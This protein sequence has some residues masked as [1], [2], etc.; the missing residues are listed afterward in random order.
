PDICIIGAGAAGL[1]A[2]EA[3][4]GHGASVV[5]VE[6]DRM[7]GGRLH[8][9]SVPARALSAAA[10]RAHALRT[11]GAFGGT[12]DE[13]KVN[14]GRIH[15]HIQQVIAA[16]APHDSAERFA[17]LG[18][19]VIKAEAKFVDRRTLRAGDRMIRARRFVIATGSRPAPVEIAGLAD[20]TAFT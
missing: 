14:F 20:V 18:I 12:P 16:L 4:K 3:A 9:G 13:P 6:A 1:A 15:D 8:L 10:G 5:L 19:D 17:A 11:A 7:G 2:A